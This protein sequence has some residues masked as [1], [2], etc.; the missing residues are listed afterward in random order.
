VLVPKADVNAVPLPDNVDMLSAAALGSRVIAVSRDAGKLAQARE[1]GAELTVEAGETAAAQIEEL[2]SSGAHV[3]VDAFGGS[4]TILPALLSLR[5]GGR[6]VQVGL[7]GKDDRG[8][9]NLPID[10]M[11]FQEL[12]LLGS[13]GCPTT[14]YPGMLS[15]V[16]KG[17]LNP[18]RL[19]T[20]TIDASEIT[21]VLEEHCSTAA[22]RHCGTVARR[23]LLNW[24]T[25]APL[26]GCTAAPQRIP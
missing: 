2:T 16:S 9:V 8:M 22:L 19:V 11:V 12:R 26:H 3:S 14:S 25:A 23:A 20:E 6:Y 18:S 4:K 21:R 7:T 17:Q 5:K 1:H 24:W 10:A 13:V 15:L